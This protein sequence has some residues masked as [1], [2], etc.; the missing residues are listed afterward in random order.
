MSE[1][2]HVVHVR[3]KGSTWCIHTYITK[4]TAQDWR[5]DGLDVSE[6]LNSIPEWAV[7]AGIPVRLW[8]FVQDVFHFKNPWE[9]P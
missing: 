8:F 5:N 2:L 1:I 7:N 3:G 9:K 4:E 6:I